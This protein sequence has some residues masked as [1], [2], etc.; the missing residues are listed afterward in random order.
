MACSSSLAERLEREAPILVTK[1]NLRE[2]KLA[3]DD[4]LNRVCTP[5]Y[6]SCLVHD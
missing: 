4:L 6:F 2:V 5:V 3:L 1:E